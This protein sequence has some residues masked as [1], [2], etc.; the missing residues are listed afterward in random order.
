M[1]NDE[2]LI[3][4]AWSNGSPRP[5]GAGYGLRMSTADR[6]RYFDPAWEDV[7]LS[8]P[9]G[10]ATRVRISHSF[11]HRCPELRCSH[12]GRWLI[13]RGHAQWPTGRP[14]AFVLIHTGGNA[15][16]MCVEMKGYGMPEQNLS[17]DVHPH[18][19]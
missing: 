16:R 8:F 9:D 6:D 4:H 15:F 5:S 11:W 2:G 10:S 18:V 17:Q 3:A 7:L 14:P 19:F 13:E 12:I 1:G